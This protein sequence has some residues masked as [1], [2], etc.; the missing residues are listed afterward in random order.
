M[1][2]V[3]VC[4]TTLFVILH[5]QTKLLLLEQ[6]DLNDFLHHT[7]NVLVILHFYNA[8]HSKYCYL[9]IYFEAWGLD[10]P[11]ECCVLLIETP[12]SPTIQG[13]YSLSV[14]VCRG[15][16]R[17]PPGLRNQKF[18][19]HSAPSRL[20][21]QRLYKSRLGNLV[22]NLLFAHCKFSEDDVDQ[23]RG[24]DCLPNCSPTQSIYY[25]ACILCIVLCSVSLSVKT[26]ILS[27]VRNL[28]FL[29][30]YCVALCISI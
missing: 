28:Y 19:F 6:M 1:C 27:S 10:V 3:Y 30:Q 9:N 14:S 17:A 8:L 26:I 12:E 4:L 5:H 22:L 15:C 20:T 23:G 7:L 11:N 24:V 21:V 2:N 25:I 16:S 29:C 18:N 13:G